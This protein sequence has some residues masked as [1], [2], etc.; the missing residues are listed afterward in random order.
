LLR[1]V[2]VFGAI[3]VALVVLAAGAKLL[4][5]EEFDEV[6]RRLFRR[7]LPQRPS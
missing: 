5:L 7:F 4:R 3:G 1:I 2:R 6:W